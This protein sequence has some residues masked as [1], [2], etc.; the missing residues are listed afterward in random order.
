M[1]V[2]VVFP[3]RN[4]RSMSTYITAVYPPSSFSF[5]SLFLPF[6]CSLP[7]TK[8]LIHRQE[9][10]TVYVSSETYN[11]TNT[12]KPTTQLKKQNIANVMVYFSLISVNLSLHHGSNCS[13][14][15]F[16]FVYHSL[17]F[18]LCLP[19]VYAFQKYIV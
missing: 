1:E 10:G 13:E 5:L 7:M 18:L 6:L 2:S 14:F 8:Y 19:H 16:G 4:G 11:K 17:P 15:C 3:G 9:C 12:C